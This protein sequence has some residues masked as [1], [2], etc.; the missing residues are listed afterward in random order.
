MSNAYRIELPP[1]DPSSAPERVKEP[2]EGARKRMGMIPNMYTRMANSAGAFET[3]LY[4]YERFRKDS[5]F[6]PAEQEVVLLSISAENGCEYCVA[7]HST[8]ADGPSRVPRQVTEAIRAGRTVPDPKLRALS[9]LAR[10]I[11]ATRGR[12]SETDVRT[13]L[14]AGYSERHI[15]ELVLAVAVKTISKYVNHLFE[16]PFDDAFKARAWFAPPRSAA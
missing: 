9:D 10:A 2:L 13:F 5:G 7:A 4:G 1:V 14:A 11:V 15:L 3:Y 16:T 8:L 6:S 12:P